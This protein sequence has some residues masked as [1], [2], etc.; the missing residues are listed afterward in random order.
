M[1]YTAKT[2][3]NALTIAKTSFTI[4]APFAEGHAVTA[5]EAAALNQ[6]LAENI[7]NNFAKRVKE[8]GEADPPVAADVL[9]A[10]LDQYV[11]EYEFGVRRSGGGRSS[12]PVEVEAMSIARDK[13]KD[14]LRAKGYKL[15][16]ISAGRI[17]ELASE[18][19]EKNPQWR[20]TAKSVVEQRNATADEVL[21]DI[22]A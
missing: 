21:E 7:R 2:Q 11:T 22:T 6:L 20:E 13:V 19:L 3:R 9:Q 14:A 18:Y 1:K 4:P 16:D 12:D 5:N 17:T 8:G 15:A 10:E